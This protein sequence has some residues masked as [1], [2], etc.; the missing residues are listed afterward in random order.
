VSAL[1]EQIGGNHYRHLHIQPVEFIHANGIPFFEAPQATSTDQIAILDKSGPE[2][3]D[4]R[5]IKFK[6]TEVIEADQRK[7]VVSE[8]VSF[9]FERLDAIGEIK[10]L[11]TT[12]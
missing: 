6:S 10:S 7:Y 8:R 9:N 3:G 2:I 4:R 1:E 5:L 11:K 12:L